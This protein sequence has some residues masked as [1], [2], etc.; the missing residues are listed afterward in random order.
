MEGDLVFLVADVRSGHG[1]TPVGVRNRFA[2]NADFFALHRNGLGH[3]LGGDVL[4]Q[5]RPSGGL[6]FV[7]DVEALLRAG[8]GVVRSRA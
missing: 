3:V 6:P 5:P 4:A 2:L 8:H 7:A 1:G